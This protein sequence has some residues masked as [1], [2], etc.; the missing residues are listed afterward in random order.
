VENLWKTGVRFSQ[1]IIFGGT[2]YEPQDLA[3]Q[4]RS[5]F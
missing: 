1:E 3:I 4:H 2:N 5:K